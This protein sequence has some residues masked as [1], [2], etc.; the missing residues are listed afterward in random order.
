M[1][2]PLRYYLSAIDPIVIFLTLAA[3]R[4]LVQSLDAER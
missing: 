4:D 3:A 1:F 2:A